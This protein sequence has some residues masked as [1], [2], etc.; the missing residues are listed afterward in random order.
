MSEDTESRSSS[1]PS[2]CN[3]PGAQIILLHV[4]IGILP[5][6][7]PS[8]LL[9]ADVGSNP[10]CLD[11]GTPARGV[12]Y[13]THKQA[14]D[15]SSTGQ[16]DDPAHVDPR[17]HPPVDTPPRAVAE[18]DADG[19]AADALGGRDGELELGRHDDGDGGAELH[20]EAARG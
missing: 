12:E 17:D 2:E 15:E 14:R 20:R 11:A 8:H 13:N 10:D 3:S 7:Q 1:D 9:P 4:P 19:R 5:L 18:A 6:S 16:R